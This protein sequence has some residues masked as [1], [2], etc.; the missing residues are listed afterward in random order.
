MNYRRASI[1]LLALVCAPLV[2]PAPPAERPARESRR[3]FSDVEYW[4]GVWDDPA[5]REWQKPIEVLKMLGIRPG[6]NVADLGAGTGYFTGLLS[7]EVGDG[8]VYA[9]DVEKKLL[10]HIATRE[11][12]RHDVVVPVLARRDDPKLPEGAIDL[13]L[14]VNTW[15]HI[16]KRP[17][18]LEHL[19]RA[20]APGGR[21]V[22]I[23]YREGDLPVGPPEEHRLP[24]DT[25]V[26]E[27]QD[28]GWTLVA[29]SRML[30]YQYY[31]VFNP[32]SRK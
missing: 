28:A 29:E 2:L 20:L 13:L 18:Y 31:L 17:R 5:R 4:A 23:D 1:P 3:P 27:F 11:D 21:L 24:R 25:V 15:H 22:L 19:D 8:R 16:D 30:P 26:Q 10:D 32:P 6:E 12:V 9:V 7:L 14:T